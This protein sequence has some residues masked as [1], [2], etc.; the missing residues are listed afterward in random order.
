M[1]KADIGVAM[2]I[3]ATSAPVTAVLPS[4]MLSIFAIAAAV[5]LW[6]PVIIVTRMP[7]A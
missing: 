2:S 6:S 7:P 5:I 4:P 3:S 1:K